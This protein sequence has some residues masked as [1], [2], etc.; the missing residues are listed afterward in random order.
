MRVKAIGEPRAG[1][2][3]L[4][5][6]S[7]RG[8]VW[9]AYQNH[10]MSSHD[11]GQLRFLQVGPTCTIKEAPSRYPDTQHGP[12]WAYQHIGYVNLA[13]GDVVEGIPC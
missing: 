7:E 6:M 2:D 3:A 1:D 5:Q 9:A 4:K 8:G 13:S 11:I 10:D 12:G